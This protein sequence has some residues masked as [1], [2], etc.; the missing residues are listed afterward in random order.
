MTKELTQSVRATQ[1]SYKIQEEND[2]MEE[3]K[4][5]QN[6]QLNILSAELHVQLHRQQLFDISEAID[7][8]FVEM[9]KNDGEQK[10]LK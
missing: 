8:E 7:N 6:G 10:D 1:P 2:D 3:K 9:M 4:K 5:G